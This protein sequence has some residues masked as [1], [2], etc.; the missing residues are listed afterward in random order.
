MR[1]QHLVLA[2]TLCVG[3]YC[4]ASDTAAIPHLEKSGDTTRL[5]V[6]GQPFLIL[7]GELHNSSSSSAEYMR[8][9][10]PKLAALHMNTVVAAVTWELIEPQEGHFDFTGVDSLIQGAKEH[11]LKLVLLWFGSWKNGGS[12]YDPAW[13]KTD[14]KRFPRALPGRSRRL[15]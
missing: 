8:P 4:V 14:L 11:D 5:I 2:L 6:N 3:S 9:I 1:L 7:G 10:W 12:T 15:R 13:I